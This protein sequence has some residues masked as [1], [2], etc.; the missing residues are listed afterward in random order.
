MTNLRVSA[1]YRCDHLGA[2]DSI[3][4]AAFTM[5]STVST[6]NPLA[7]PRS[8]GSQAGPTVVERAKVLRAAAKDKDSTSGDGDPAFPPNGWDY[9]SI[10]SA[11]PPCL[12]KSLRGRKCLEYAG[13]SGA[14]DVA[15]VLVVQYCSGVS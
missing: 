5:S 10:N 14:D 3:N 2:C 7:P 8:S 12:S 4:R 13:T 15:L 11:A 1:Q 6:V 9:A